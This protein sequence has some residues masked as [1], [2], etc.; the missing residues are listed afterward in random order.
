ML[1]RAIRAICGTHFIFSHLIILKTY[2]EKYKVQKPS[3]FAKNCTKIE[4]VMC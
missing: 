1:L 3:L 2:Y 4:T